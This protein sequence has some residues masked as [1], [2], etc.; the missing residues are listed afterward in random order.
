[1]EANPPEIDAFNVATA[2]L[3]ENN[4]ANNIHT[5][6]HWEENILRREKRE[7]LWV[8]FGCTEAE[9]IH[10][11]QEWM[12]GAAVWDFTIS[13]QILYSRHWQLWHT[14]P[15]PKEVIVDETS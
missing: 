4:G 8:T 2:D 1:M 12:Q 9:Y 7:S 13:Q 15:G 5:T 14:F 10:V 6:Q 3:V 11:H